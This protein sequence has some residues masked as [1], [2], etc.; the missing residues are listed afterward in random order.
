VWRKIIL[1]NH[2]S[3]LYRGFTISEHCGIRYGEATVAKALLDFLYLR[4]IPLAFHS[5][6]LSLA[7]E[8]RLNLEEFSQADRD[9]FA[10]YVSGS[11]IYKMLLIYDNLKSGFLKKSNPCGSRTM[12]AKRWYG[13]ILVSS[14]WRLPVP[15]SD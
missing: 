8:L 1:T 5:W 13:I 11:G 10:R 4:N 3:D 7:E 12:N 15:G 14:T 6:N 9:E 2:S